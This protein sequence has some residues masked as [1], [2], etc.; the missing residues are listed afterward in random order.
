LVAFFLFLQAASGLILTVEGLPIQ[1]LQAHQDQQSPPLAA[2]QVEVQE[3]LVGSLHHGGG[4]GGAL[5]R[6][7][8]GLLTLWMAV[9]G[10]WIYAK[11]RARSRNPRS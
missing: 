1:G 9:S 11:V 4:A 6:L 5:Y 3:D 10:A 8:L 2:S 7:A